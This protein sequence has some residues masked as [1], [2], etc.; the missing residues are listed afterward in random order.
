[1]ASKRRMVSIAAVWIALPILGGIA[2]ASIEPIPPHDY[3]WHLAMGRIIALTGELPTSNLF[4]YTVPAD[5]PFANQPWLGQWLMFQVVEWLGHGGGVWLRN[6]LLLVAM[7]LVTWTA[8]SRSKDARATGATLL[9]AIALA[10]PVLTVRTRMFAFVPFAV[11]LWA[12]AGFADGRLSRRWLAAVPIAAIVWANVH[13]SFILALALAGA[14]AAGVVVDGLIA[15]RRVDWT[16]ATPLVITTL[17][18]TVACMLTPLGLDTY[19]YVFR[20]ALTSPVASSVSEWLPPDVTTPGGLLFVIVTV[21]CLLVLAWR[22]QHVSIGDALVFAGTFYLAASAQRSAFFW[23]MALPVVMG[24]HL[25]AM[26]PARSREE[27]TAVT[28]A[29]N[30]ALI[31]LGLAATLAVQPGIAREPLLELVDNGLTRR[32]G[33]GRFVLNHE[34]AFE[35][36]EKVA[37]DERRRVFHDQALG[38]M[39]EFALTTPERPRQVAFVDQRMEFVPETVW[40]EF[41]AIISA[42]DAAALRRYDVDTLLLGTESQWPLIQFAIAS[43]EWS[44]EGLDQSHVLFYRVSLDGAEHPSEQ[45]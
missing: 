12:V 18:T 35:L 2:A 8:Q 16:R 28:S 33:E 5:A 6:I 32:T 3:W 17:V 22:R 21:A 37:R 13:G 14:I 42:H 30:V 26:L 31:S 41:F 39:L 25:A 19:V 36:V 44:L 34:H 15:E 23:A 38:G 9:I 4:L 40:Q 24:P 45:Q 7:G 20:L 29:L 43:R 1:M 27:E 11:T 10:Y